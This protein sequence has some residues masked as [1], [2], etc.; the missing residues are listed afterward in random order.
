MIIVMK[1]E[2]TRDHIDGV[3]D[4]LTKLGFK[5]HLSQGEER[6]IVGAIGDKRNVEAETLL[7]MPGVLEI[8]PIKRP[9]KRVSRE[10]HPA[11]TVVTAGNVRIGGSADLLVMAGPCCVESRDQ[12]METALA[13][14]KAG[15]TV[16][17]GGAFK[18]RTSPYSF[19]GLGV[20]GL[21]LLAE[22]RELTGMPI[23]TEVMDPED[24]DACAEYAD[25]LQLGARNMQNFSL[26]KKV[27]R[28]QK[29]VMLKRGMAATIEEWL[30]SAEYIVN[31]GNDQVI[32]CERGIR[33]V[34]TQYTRNTLDVSAIPVIKRLSHLPIIADPS[35]GTGKWY[36]VAPL[37][38]ASVVAGTDG[39]MIEVHPRP[40]E[41]LSDGPQ[42]LTPRSFTKLMQELQAMKQVLHQFNP[43]WDDLTAEQQLA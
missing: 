2:A 20:K 11:D 6:T 31:E 24:L 34:E 23:I 25:I 27:G 9:F 36:L 8:I 15:A 10:F 26:L 37:A 32:L 38:K 18:P 1:T 5:T 13:V 16:L 14:R 12:L 7:R 17:R 42:A 39:L 4:R 41:A 30:M 40:E 19:Q 22:A 43:D 35:H 28:L 21:E 3:V 29:P 33:T